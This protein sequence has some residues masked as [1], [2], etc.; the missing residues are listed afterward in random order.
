[1]TSALPA[2]CS[3]KLLNGA[4]SYGIPSFELM[5]NAAGSMMP[6]R[7]T[8]RCLELKLSRMVLPTRVLSEPAVRNLI[9]MH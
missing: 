8:E 3:K 6:C 5:R 1:M 4:F 7:F 2:N 9:W